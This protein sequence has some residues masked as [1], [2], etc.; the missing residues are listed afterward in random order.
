MK[1]RKRKKKKRL[2]SSESMKEAKDWIK[3][4]RVDQEDDSKAYERLTPSAVS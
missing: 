3:I 1:K 4:D 2:D